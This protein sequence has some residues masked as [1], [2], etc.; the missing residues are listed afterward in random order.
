MGQHRHRFQEPPPAPKPKPSPAPSALTPDAASTVATSPGLI[1]AVTVACEADHGPRRPHP[2]GLTTIPADH[3]V[4]SIKVPPLPAL[5]EIPLVL[6]RVGTRSGNTENQMITYINLDPESDFAPPAW[7][8][9]VGTVI[10]ARKD[11]RPL[12]PHHV[13]GVWM[14]CDRIM[15][16]FGDGQAPPRMYN[17][18]SFERWWKGYVEEQKTFRGGKGGEKDPEDWRAMKVAL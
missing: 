9:G 1:Q 10:A 13:E 7:Q 4:V 14:Y 18:A 16:L 6:H 17:R 15:D 5:I 3:P 8:S 11:K 2:W 12:L